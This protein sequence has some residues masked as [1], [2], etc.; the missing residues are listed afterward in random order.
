MLRHALPRLPAA[1][2]MV[3]IPRL[4]THRPP[5]AH[6]P[7]RLP[8]IQPPWAWWNITATAT[9]CRCKAPC[10]G[11][12]RVPTRV[13][14]RRWWCDGGDPIRF[15]EHQRGHGVA[16]GAHKR[17]TLKLKTALS[18]VGCGCPTA[19]ATLAGQ[20]TSMRPNS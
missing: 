15:H 19:A 8:S 12:Q 11:W 2:V 13:E 20:K 6:R 3:I 1:L 10:M 18:W 9:G 17:F 4:V 5:T 14:R 16:R 7:R